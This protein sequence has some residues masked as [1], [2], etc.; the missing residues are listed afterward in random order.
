VN[1]RES[2]PVDEP[3]DIV[4]ADVSF[5][6]L[7]LALPPSLAKLRDGGDVVALVKPQFEAGRDAVGK[8]GV[9][10]DADARAAAVVAVANDLAARGL[11]VVAITPS[12]IA[13]REGNREIFVHA[14]K[15]AA[16][17]D[18]ASLAARAKEAAG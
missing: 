18:E 11:G 15:G 2:A 3:V 9:V 10:R 13:G 14:R 12:P 7:R 5:I 17:L 8:G 1:A 4:V 16:S 6:S